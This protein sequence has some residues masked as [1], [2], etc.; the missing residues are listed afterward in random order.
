MCVIAKKKR[1]KAG[2]EF[3]YE[4]KRYRVECEKSDLSCLGC[5][6]NIPCSKGRTGCLAKSSDHIFD[7]CKRDH[8]I[9]VRI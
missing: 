8:V 9:F 4:G 6:L 5:S 7:N 3:E 1:M 2:E